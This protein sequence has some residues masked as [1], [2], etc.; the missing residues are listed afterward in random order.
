MTKTASNGV[1]GAQEQYD[2]ASTSWVK[3]HLDIQ[4]L[5][6]VVYQVPYIERGVK[7]AQNPKI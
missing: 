6:R 3:E 2:L 1:R 5:V 7:G 4:V